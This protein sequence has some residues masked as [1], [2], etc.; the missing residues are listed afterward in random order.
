M[1]NWTAQQWADY[2]QRVEAVMRE[3]GC[4]R[5]D[6]E[7]VVDAQRGGLKMKVAIATVRTEEALQTWIDKVAHMPERHDLQAW[8]SQA[9][10]SANNRQSESESIVVEMAW[11]ATASGRPETLTLD[12]SDFD[13]INEE[14]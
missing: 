14:V 13:F 11:I 8:L 7:G 12:P 5:S 6:A 10:E 4:D 9:E 2:E 1:E 3:Y